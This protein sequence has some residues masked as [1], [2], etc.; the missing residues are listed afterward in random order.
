MI[1]NVYCLI[2]LIFLFTNSIFAGENPSL[3][4]LLS[5]SDSV[6]TM[7]SV[8]LIDEKGYQKLV[9]KREGKILVVNFWATWCVPC[10]KEFPDLVKVAKEYQDQHVEFV[11]I[12]ADLED[13]IDKKVIP[14]LNS[15]NVSFKNYLKSV[16]DD[17]DFINMVNPDWQGA[18]PVTIVYDVGGKLLE[19]HEGMAD[20][21]GFKKMVERALAKPES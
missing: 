12:S 8:D 19:F 18:L 3:N 16:V 7:I 21:Q 20:Y 13:E 15:N 10:R 17:G 4:A 1:M 9:E 6:A 2:L 11:G 5:G 14:F